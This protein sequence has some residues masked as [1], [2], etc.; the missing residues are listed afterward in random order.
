MSVSVFISLLN[1]VC[2]LAL[3]LIPLMASIAVP[4]LRLSRDVVDFGTCLVGQ[5]VEMHVTLYNRSQSASAWVAKKGNHVA[6]RYP[7][8][9]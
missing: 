2:L 1:G 9:S 6:M 5:P 3:Q 4:T 7:K 8:K